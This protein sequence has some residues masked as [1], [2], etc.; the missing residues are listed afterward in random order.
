ML[1]DENL[2]FAL[3]A[4]R[5]GFL[6]KDQL[7]AVAATLK[8]GP[9]VDLGKSL[10]KRNVMDAT[11]A[12]VLWDLVGVQ[13]AMLGDARKAMGGVPMDDEVR[14]AIHAAILAGEVVAPMTDKGTIDIPSPLEGGT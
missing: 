12:K 11:Q 4:Q 2:L 5:I 9:D 7:L 1:R 13:Q 6:T 8:P 14:A 3:Y 10:V